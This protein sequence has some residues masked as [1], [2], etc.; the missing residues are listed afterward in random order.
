MSD[1]IL[2][3]LGYFILSA[4]IIIPSAYYVALVCWTIRNKWC[5]SISKSKYI[6]IL[7]FIFPPLAWYEA[8]VQ[9][10]KKRK[11]VGKLTSIMMCIFI[12]FF[13]FAFSD[14]FIVFSFKYNQSVYYIDIVMLLFMFF[15]PVCI[16]V[17]EIVRWKK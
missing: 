5:S 13:W 16:L 15:L 9:M 7:Y 12:F 3:I 1:F 10:N 4:L 11:N 6:I 8:S 2:N 17:S 14:S